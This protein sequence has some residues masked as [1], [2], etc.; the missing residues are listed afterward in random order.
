MNVNCIV[1]TDQRCY[2]FVYCIHLLTLVTKNYPLKNLQHKV[3]VLKRRKLC[4][5]V[6]YSITVPCSVAYF[7]E[8]QF[9]IYLLLRKYMSANSNTITDRP[10]LMGVQC[11]YQHTCLFL[12][13]NEIKN[14]PS[15]VSNSNSNSY[16]SRS[17]HF[18]INQT[19]RVYSIYTHLRWLIFVFLI[20]A[21]YL[22]NL[23]V[24]G[25]WKHFELG[26]NR[27]SYLV[28]SEKL[29]LSSSEP[30]FG[31]IAEYFLKFQEY[32]LRFQEHF[33]IVLLDHITE[34]IFLSSHPNN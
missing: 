15:D 26:F 4:D 17:T 20:F 8:K 3:K 1:P 9:N 11:W 24:L 6:N 28:P 23:L 30:F 31:M 21:M 10:K 22:Q 19:G 7:G 29:Q 18:Q 25:T 14:I 34:M 2:C 13:I 12:K 32:F 27:G 33:L 5:E 16:S